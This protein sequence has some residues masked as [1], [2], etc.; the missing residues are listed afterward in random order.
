M[1]VDL[2]MLIVF[3]NVMCVEVYPSTHV[4]MNSLRKVENI[5]MKIKMI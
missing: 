4:L 1:Y 3:T 2:C 5:R